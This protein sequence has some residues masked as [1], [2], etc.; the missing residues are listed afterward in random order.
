MLS[1]SPERRA[2]PGKLVRLSGGQ[3]ASFLKGSRQGYL[4]GIGGSVPGNVFHV[5]VYIEVFSAEAGD[6][7]YPVSQVKP[8]VT[9]LLTS[10]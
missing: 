4:L 6:S 5:S 10:N 2:W 9:R 3:G 7:S 8:S 1:C